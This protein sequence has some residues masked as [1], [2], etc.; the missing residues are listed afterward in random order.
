MP[1][2]R[3]I[4]DGL[5]RAKAPFRPTQGTVNNLLDGPRIPQWENAAAVIRYLGRRPDDYLPYWRA[6]KAASPAA[7]APPPDDQHVLD[8]TGAGSE[9][10]LKSLIRSRGYASHNTLLIRTPLGGR[11][12][13][14]WQRVE[15]EYVLKFV[16][17]AISRLRNDDHEL[18]AR[19]LFGIDAGWR[20][21]SLSQRREEVADILHRSP[22]TIQRMQ[23]TL[24]TEVALAMTAML[25]TLSPGELQKVIDQRDIITPAEADTVAADLRGRRAALKAGS[26][27]ASPATAAAAPTVP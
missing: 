13:D 18:V 6:A 12:D 20:D 1:S 21:M 16:D 17:A 8:L 5:R 3:A 11:G 22:R 19:C 4:A 14:E 10:E 25:K 26:A 15:M 24:I 9:L 27:G 7:E 23:T 2:G